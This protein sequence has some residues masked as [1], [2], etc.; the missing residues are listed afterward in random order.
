[1]WNLLEAKRKSKLTFTEIAE[2]TGLTNAFVAQLFYRQVITDREGSYHIT[3]V[4]MD[5][6][7]CL[8]CW[9]QGSLL[10]TAS[11]AK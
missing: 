9:G 11:D 2:R 10:G 1:M 3:R 8:F 6:D 7:R 5:I 4:C